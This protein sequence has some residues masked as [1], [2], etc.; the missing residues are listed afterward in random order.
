MSEQALAAPAQAG[1]RDLILAFIAERRDAKAKSKTKSQGEDEGG[2][3]E[4]ADR[5]E[6]SVWLADAA[7]RV[8]QLRA[9]THVLKATHPKAEG[10]SLYV[11]PATMAAQH[12]VGTHSLQGPQPGD[13]VGNAAALDVYK[14]LKLERQGVQLLDALLE[15]EPSAVAAL[16][17]DPQVARRHAEA[18]TGLVRQQVGGWESHT[19]AK[20]VYWCMPGADPAEDA[21][22]HLLQPLFSSVL[23]HAVHADISDARFG[24]ANKAA[25]K[26]FHDDQPH[27]EPYRDYRG[28][29]MRKLGGTK[30][31]NISQLNSERGGVNYLLA[32][33]P[34]RWRSTRWSRLSKCSSALELFLYF[35]DVRAQIAELVA[36]LKQ[37]PGSTMKVR[38]WRK[39]CV[40]QLALTLLA[41]GRAVAADQPAGWTGRT[42]C[43]LPPCEQIW[44]DPDRAAVPQ[45]DASP[46]DQDF[47]ATRE[48]GDWADALA[49][50]FACWL[51]DRLKRAG[52]PLGVVEAREWARAFWVEV[53]WPT[54][55]QR[56]L[57]EENNMTGGF[58]D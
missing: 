49:T 11:L 39:D 16:D 15:A 30:P 57:R 31:Q 43:R 46:E 28:L 8:G 40:N 13:I 33:L 51:N 12:D 36:G 58:H 38:E 56:R 50:Q 44:L 20:Q 23:A 37:A 41:F 5:F 10:S 42:P 22:F 2:Q 45:P 34:P 19:L 47:R 55:Q 35:E 53:D 24:E 54:P 21:S 29:V 7:Q 14:L 25:R 27:A 3:A 6:P 17:A 26:A 52:L 9:V 18:F 4:R 32:S 48:R 1:W